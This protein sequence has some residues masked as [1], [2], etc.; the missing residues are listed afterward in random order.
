MYE[1]RN[2]HVYRL[3]LER[4]GSLSDDDDSGILALLSIHTFFSFWGTEG[5]IAVG[6]C[7]HLL[8]KSVSLK[9][10]AQE[11]MSITKSHVQYHTGKFAGGFSNDTLQPAT[12]I[13]RP[14]YVLIRVSA[15]RRSAT[16]GAVYSA[17][18]AW[19]SG[20]LRL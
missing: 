14:D 2:H 5:K 3:C 12:A 20:T 6:L 8:S 1:F 17:Y 9:C 18:K 19:C 16:C 10:S 11:V 13:Q 15:S 4:C 7:L